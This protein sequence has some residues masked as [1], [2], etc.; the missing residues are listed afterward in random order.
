MFQLNDI[1]KRFP[2]G[3]HELLRKLYEDTVGPSAG[4]APKPSFAS[5]KKTDIEGVNFGQYSLFY[6]CLV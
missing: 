4:E 6:T 2:V 5:L 3:Y 1:R